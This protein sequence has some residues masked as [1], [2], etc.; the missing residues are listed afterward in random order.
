MN[1]LNRQDLELHVSILGWLYIGASAIGVVFGLL[2][3]TLLTG[4]GTATGDRTA[5]LVLSIIGTSGGLLVVLLSLPGMVAGYALI[6]RLAWG[7]V[8]ALVIGFLGLVLVP[9]GTAIGV[10]TFWVMLQDTATEFFY[11]PQPA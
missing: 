7:R 11:P 5:T 10:Y 4:I 3:F 6:R 2:V 8:L 9:V 1:Q